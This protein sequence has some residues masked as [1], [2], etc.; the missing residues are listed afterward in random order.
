RL[1]NST[2]H[3]RELNPLCGDEIELFVHLRD[4]QVDEI[5]WEGKGCAI[6]QA[7]ASMLSDELLAK[8][9]PELRA[10]KTQDVLQLL[11]IPIGPVRLK[12]ANLPLRTLQLALQQY[13][14]SQ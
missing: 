13:E 2:L 5:K 6:S 10:L 7:A 11:A 4:G 9:V 3:F 8:T 14:G 1:T 12:C